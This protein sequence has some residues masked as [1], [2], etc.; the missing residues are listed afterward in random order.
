MRETVS[1]VE[2]GQSF[3]PLALPVTK[4]VCV[5]VFKIQAI[6]V[7]TVVQSEEGSFGHVTE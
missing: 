7:G 3:L 6:G 4:F 1:S 2:T 5:Y